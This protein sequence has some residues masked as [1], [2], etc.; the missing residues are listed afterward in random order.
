MTLFVAG[1]RASC[2]GDAL[3]EALDD[4]RRLATRVKRNVAVP[5]HIGN[6]RLRG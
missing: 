6:E 1:A 3:G 4:Q 2:S 5:R